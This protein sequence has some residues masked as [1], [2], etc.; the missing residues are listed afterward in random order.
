MTFPLFPL[1]SMLLLICY[2]M[3]N[4]AGW[5]LRTRI[6]TVFMLV[7]KENIRAKSFQKRFFSQPGIRLHQHEYPNHVG[8]N[9]TFVSWCAPCGHEG[10]TNW[11]VA[12]E[13]LLES[14]KSGKKWT[15][16]ATG[17]WGT[18]KAGTAFQVRQGTQDGGGFKT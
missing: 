13:L 1:L 17:K 16:R 8:E 14:M 4:M 6:F 15:E 2:P 18:R 9:C 3:R 12:P 11:G 10:C 5:N 7:I